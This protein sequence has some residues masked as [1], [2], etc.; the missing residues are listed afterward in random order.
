[1]ELARLKG[2]IWERLERFTGTKSDPLIPEIGD[3]LHEARSCVYEQ[4]APKP[5]DKRR[6]PKW[7]REREEKWDKWCS[8]LEHLPSGKGVIMNAKRAD[9]FIRDRATV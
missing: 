3:L 5:T 6:I 8:S 1:V 2:E 7:K 4:A 9:V